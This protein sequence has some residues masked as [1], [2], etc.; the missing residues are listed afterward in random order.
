MTYNYIN[1]WKIRMGIMNE[2]G[3]SEMPGVEKFENLKHF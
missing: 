3:V 2:E 1:L